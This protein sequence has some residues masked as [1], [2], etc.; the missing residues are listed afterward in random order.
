[1]ADKFGWTG[2]LLCCIAFI[3]IV[4]ALETGR[5]WPSVAAY[6]F[7]GLAFASLLVAIWV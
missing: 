7:S 5:R 2:M 6:V 3:L 4:V 1:M